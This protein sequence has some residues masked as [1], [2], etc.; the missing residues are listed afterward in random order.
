MRRTELSSA[1]FAVASTASLLASSPRLT[2]ALASLA[3]HHHP[4]HLPHTRN[5]L[6]LQWA[7]A[8]PAWDPE[9]KQTDQLRKR[10]AKDAAEAQFGEG[11][12]RALDELKKMALKKMAEANQGVLL[13]SRV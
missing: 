12:D 8:V 10:R 4:T 11:V 2:K 3:Y 7:P 9:L 1:C 5:A 6:R 13:G